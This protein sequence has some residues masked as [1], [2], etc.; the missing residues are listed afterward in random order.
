MSE[1]DN[2]RLYIMFLRLLDSQL[3]NEEQE[4]LRQLFLTHPEIL[5]QYLLHLTSG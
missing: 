5:Q 4:A 3:P 1:H 2:H